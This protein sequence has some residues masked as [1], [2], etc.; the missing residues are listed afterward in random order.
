VPENAREIHA[1]AANAL[2]TP[3]VEEWATW[4]FE[5]PVR[6]RALWE[7]GPE[8][9][10]NGEDGVDCAACAK[11]DSDYVWTDANWRLTAMEP[12]GLPIV[13]ILEPRAHYDAPSDL[14]DDLAREQGVMLGRVE[15]AVLSIGDIGRVHIGRWGEGAAHLHWWFIARPAGLPQLA[16]SMAEIW[17]EVL[18]PTP[19]QVWRANVAS[20]AEAM[21][22]PHREARESSSPP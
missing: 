18:P 4:P 16:S 15:R 14:P 17:D 2:R 13:L 7:P 20:V 1:R 5:G 22:R 6:P 19:E 8:P 9:Q 12:S 21:R 3:A 11:P 10:R